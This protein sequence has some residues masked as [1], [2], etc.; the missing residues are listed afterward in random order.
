MGRAFDFLVEQKAACIF[1]ETGELIGM[2]NWMA[3]RA[4]TPE[5]G[6]EIIN[7][8]AKAA[9]YYATLGHA[10]FAPGNADGGLTTI[11]EIAR[12]LC[13]ERPIHLRDPQAG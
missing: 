2:E 6:Q 12:R 10:S 7:T 4:A 11:E 13:E 3:Q 5:L 9:R 1:E 8:V